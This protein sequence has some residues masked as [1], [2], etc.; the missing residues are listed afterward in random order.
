MNKLTDTQASVVL[1]MA[2]LTEIGD[3]LLQAKAKLIPLIDPK[4]RENAD[5]VIDVALEGMFAI[6][7]ET[8]DQLPEEEQV[9]IMVGMLDSY[10]SQAMRGRK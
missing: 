9:G 8:L 6:S 3:S 10:L 2:A 4:F 1:D 5:K 7:K